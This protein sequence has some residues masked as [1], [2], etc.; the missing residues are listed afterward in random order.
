MIFILAVLLHPE[1]AKK[2]QEEIDRVVG[3]GRLPTFED[4][5]SL[6]YVQAL[7]YETRRW[8]SGM[9]LFSVLSYIVL[10]G[11]QLFHSVSDL[12]ATT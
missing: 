2:A 9:R 8:V 4:R 7:V 6:P 1:A 10:D 5:E 3:P 12:S 11:I